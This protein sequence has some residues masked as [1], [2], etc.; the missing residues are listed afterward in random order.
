ME[1][2]NTPESFGY[3]FAQSWNKV[4][5][6]GCA[7]FLFEILALALGYGVFLICHGL[8][9][10][11]SRLVIYWKPGRKFLIDVLKIQDEKYL[12]TLPMTISRFTFVGVY[13]AV[14]IVMIFWGCKVL[15]DGGFLNQNVIYFYLSQK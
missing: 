10:V 5:R 9:L 15:F 13:L 7:F 2:K 12:V 14:G 1:G 8:W 11:G 6:Y 3:G 4:L